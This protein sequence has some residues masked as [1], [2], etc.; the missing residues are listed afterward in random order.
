MDRV[1]FY[2]L[3][4]MMNGRNLKKCENLIKEFEAGKEAQD[5][6]DIIELY[7]VKKYFDN[8]IFLIDWTAN[9]ISHYQKKVRQFLGIV[10]RFFKSITNDNIIA[11]YFDV[12]NFYKSDFWELID[13]FK[14]YEV[15]TEE[16]FRKMLNIS[17]VS[18][19]DLLKFKEI[20]EYFGKIIR[21]YMLNN[22]SSVQL[23]LDRYEL[24]HIR[25]KDLIYFPKELSN[26][27]KETIIN[28]YIDSEEPNL[29]YL[30][31]IANIQSSKDKIEITPKTLLK[32]KRKAEG[33]EKKLFKENSGIIMGTAVC[34]SKSMNEEVTL[35]RDDH[36]TTATYSTKWIE[37]NQ[38]YP[39]LLNNFIH[40]FEFVDLQMRCT[41]VN[42]YN[43]MGVFE[44]FINYIFPTCLYKRSGVRPQ[45]CLL[46]TSNGRIL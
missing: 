46:I 14:V 34:F 1:K 19:Y 17:K 11:L 44:R 6:N 36:S 43:E 3:N 33:Q 12:D 16:R 29:N 25:E 32:A 2:S 22:S 20:A 41:L 13:K 9:D 4:D 45:E 15:I 27:D 7:N 5:I 38:D 42:K 35:I 18:L 23:L 28:T 40:L 24:K 39:T 10:A 31:L 8:K 21:D 30:R 37:E 26:S